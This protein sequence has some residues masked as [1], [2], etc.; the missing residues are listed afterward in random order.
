VSHRSCATT[1]GGH[2]DYGALRRA[3]PKSHRRGKNSGKVRETPL[4]ID[5]SPESS[6]RLRVGFAI[7]KNLYRHIVTFRIDGKPNVSVATTIDP[8]AQREPTELS[9]FV[10]HALGHA[11]NIGT[12]RGCCGRYRPVGDA[13]SAPT[14]YRTDRPAIF[15]VVSGARESA[16]NDRRR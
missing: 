3:V 5:F 7:P 2:D 15:D 10:P 9:A 4:G 1:V 6:I 8:A 12:D 14:V 16:S 11:V 13:S